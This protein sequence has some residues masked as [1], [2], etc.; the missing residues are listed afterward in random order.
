MNS[1]RTIEGATLISVGVFC[2]AALVNITLRTNS[3]LPSDADT[4]VT[5]LPSVVISA[6]RLSAA[7]KAQ[8]QDVHSNAA[9]ALATERTGRH[10]G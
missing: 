5:P 2:A 4:A 8:L 3:L 9:D 10:A 7:E 6:H 1:I